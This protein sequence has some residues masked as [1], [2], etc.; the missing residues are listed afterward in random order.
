[1]NTI[2]EEL[3][4][5]IEKFWGDNLLF[6]C[7]FGSR[8][9]QENK[10]DSDIDLLVV[11]KKTVNDPYLK[12][13]F[14]NKFIEFQLKY[15]LLPDYDYP[16]EIISI[17]KLLKAIK[18]YGFVLDNDVVKIDPIKPK[19][20]TFFN[21]Y[22]QWL[23]AMAGPNLFLVG[24]RKQ[25]ENLRKEAMSSVLTIAL[26]AKND[27]VFELKNFKEIL[28]EKGKECLGFCNTPSTN[29]YLNE[30]IPEII[31]HLVKNAILDIQGDRFKLNKSE[32]IRL[33]TSLSNFDDVEYKKNFLGYL[34]ENN[35]LESLYKSLNIGIDFIKK[36]SGTIEFKPEQDIKERFL[37][38]IPLNGTRLNEIID[39]FNKKILDGSIKQ[40]SPNY[41]AF[42]DAGNS[43]AGLCAE[44]LIA[45]TNQNLIA[46]TKSAPTATFAEIQVIRWF[47]KLIGFCD[48]NDFPKSA[49]DVGGEMVG[50]GTMANAVAI[51]AARNYTFPMSRA[52]GINIGEI[53]PILIVAGSTMHHYS[54]VAAFWWLGMG[55]ENIV[56]INTL[57]DYRFDCE[58][59][60]NKLTEYNNG[61]T[62]KV[63][64]VI[65]QAGDSRTTTIENFDRVVDIT[66]RHNV[67][68][69]VDACHGGVLIFSEKFREKLKS[70]READSI[71]VDP[72]KGLCVTYPSSIVLFKDISSFE[73][74]T[75]STDITIQKGSYDL[76]Q[77]TPFVG[78]KSFDSLK[79]WFLIKNL[80]LHGIEKLIDY[81]LMLAQQWRKTIESSLLFMSLNEVELNSV[82]FSISPEKV[83]KN[84]PDIN[85]L[86]SEMI[87]LINKNIHDQVYKG[88]YICIHNFDLISLDD[89]STSDKN[90]VL[91][92]TFG[93]P[94]TTCDDF[95]EYI[96]YLDDIAMS[97]IKTTLKI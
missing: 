51:L 50:G 22:R 43:L 38:D 35:N 45:F 34:T 41:L 88:G 33:L 53:K 84:F 28:L 21:E 16:G 87:G 70:L 58:D 71:S 13:E 78:S 66:K 26:L 24:D 65:C 32:A 94:Y 90:R 83:R 40:S 9:R 74:L 31:D 27:E 3:K 14:K 54:H 1:M 42:P 62:S 89:S 92:V 63:V 12:K 2:L 11:L 93:N 60:E 47:R 77:M 72:H 10:H 86:D 20:W 61:T 30:N 25:Y 36:E 96:N 57:K 85:T 81:R 46:T 95:P 82:V 75:K 37:D 15:N 29:N 76:G 64:A 52:K 49:V 44:L 67:W 79:L 97:S 19:E 91:G 69:H 48:S 39:E 6:A 68:L 4:E 55:E 73:S 56:Y 59:L 23:C 5:L 7:I 17:W 8:A 18:G 80:G